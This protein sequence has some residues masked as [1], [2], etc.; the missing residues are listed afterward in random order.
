[1]LNQ[2]Q[3]YWR[4]FWQFRKIQ[5]MRLF[6][7]RGNFFFW[8]LIS[9]VWTLFNLF[10]FSLIIRAGG[11]IGGWNP[12]E[13]YLLLGIFTIIDS[14]TWSFFYHNMVLYTQAIYQGKLSQLLTKPIDTQFLLMVQSNSYTNAFRL[15]I[16]IAIF[17]F[18]YRQLGLTHNW[19]QWLIFV[20]LLVNSLML[21]YALWFIIS[22]LAFWVEKLDNINEII[23]MLRRVFQVP[24][25]I[26][27]G[28]ASFIFTVLF[29]LALISSIPSEFLLSKLSPQ[30][31]AI[32]FILTAVAVLIS[33][34]FFHF[35]LKK[36]SG[37]GQ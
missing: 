21:L 12:Q 1:M 2:A 8:T 20:L 17:L 11:G 9:I 36:Y 26:Y 23:P 33:R 32:S 10:F 15:F 28:V 5:L 4:V 37:V 25:S 14:F 13:I 34:Q 35:S 27:T 6:E 31:F 22:T 29:P 3:S 7:Y 16:G 30:W 19:W 18:S 24:R